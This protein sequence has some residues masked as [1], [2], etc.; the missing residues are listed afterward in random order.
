M[1]L[2]QASNTPS[3]SLSPRMKQGSTQSNQSF[4]IP[5]N[6]P[7]VPSNAPTPAPRIYS[8]SQL[9]NQSS[10][11]G[12]G[13]GLPLGLVHSN[14]RGDVENCSTC[15]CDTYSPNPFKSGQCNNCFH[16]H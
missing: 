4:S 7:R 3:P 9:S 5:S 12:L 15:G 2:P 14:S 13:N 8:G 11:N 1:C 16:K 6:V 10:Q